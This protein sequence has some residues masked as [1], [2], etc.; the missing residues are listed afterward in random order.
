MV[1]ETHQLKKNMLAGTVAATGGLLLS[2]ISYPIYLHYLN[3]ELYGVWAL[4][5]VIIFFS[6]IGN[7]GLDEA[8]IKY[9]AEENADKNF[10]NIISYISSGINLLFFI[11]IIIFIIFVILK[12]FFIL[13]LNLNIAYRKIF[14][15]MYY[16]VIILSL[17][18][19]IVNFV[20]AILKGLGYFDEASYILLFSRVIAFFI[21]VTFL[22]LQFG[23][24]ALYYGQITFCLS[25]LLLSSMRIIKKIGLFYRPITYENEKLINLLKFGGALTISKLISLFLE[26]LIK[27]VIARYVGLA[28]VTF[29]E[30][31]NKIVQQIRSLLE[32]GIS[33]IM[34]EVSRLTSGGETDTHKCKSIMKKA[35][36]INVI[37]S[38]TSFIF[39]FIF[40]DFILRIWLKREYN[41]NL[42]IALRIILFGYLLNTFSIPAYYY[43]MG[44]GKVKYCLYNHFIQSFLNFLIILLLMYIN[45]V[46]FTTVI[47]SYSFALGLSALVL[48]ISYHKKNQSN[49]GKIYT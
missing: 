33:A 38:S 13:S 44:I 4:L 23:I 16:A 39:F 3:A 12:N 28:E 31:A 8:I 42:I 1:N 5:T 37:I 47:L 21:S 14:Q 35:N 43:F 17:L 2:I 9:V 45:V 46:N 11:S 7:I 48:I 15:D 25:L 22:H 20:N 36:K 29:F 27:F 34:P 18:T 26:P 10:L 24:W 49:F 32:R 19:I 41:V 30:I 6:S 40:G